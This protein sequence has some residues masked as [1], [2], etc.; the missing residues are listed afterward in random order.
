MLVTYPVSV[1]DQFMLVHAFMQKDSH[2]SK[3]ILIKLK[4]I[5]TRDNN[6]KINVIKI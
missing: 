2:T 4:N 3:Y 6:Y 1:K 5:Y